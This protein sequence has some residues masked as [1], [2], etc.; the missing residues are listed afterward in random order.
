MPLYAAIYLNYNILVEFTD[1]RFINQVQWDMYKSVFSYLPLV[2][3][4]SS[5]KNAYPHL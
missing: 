4:A 2:A 1:D 5:K 3:A